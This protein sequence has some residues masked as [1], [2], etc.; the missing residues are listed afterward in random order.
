MS[1]CDVHL[2]VSSHDLSRKVILIC[3]F[4]CVISKHL[5]SVKSFAMLRCGLLKNKIF[6]FL[7]L[8]LYLSCITSPTCTNASLIDWIKGDE[9]NVKPPNILTMV[10]ISDM[11]VRD[12]K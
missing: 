9:W 1:I 11:R 6:R 4:Q 3:I 10:E 2:S 7:W 8:I 12:I 5:K